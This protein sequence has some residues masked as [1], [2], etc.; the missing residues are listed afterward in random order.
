M[1]LRDKEYIVFALETSCFHLLYVELVWWSNIC[2]TKRKVIW[3]HVSG[4]TLFVP[5]LL[6]QLFVNF[7]SSYSLYE[8]YKG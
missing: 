7:F 5:P 2:T 3:L 6:N 1:I 4:G 8:F